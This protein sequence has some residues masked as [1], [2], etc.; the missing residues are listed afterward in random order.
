MDAPRDAV[1]GSSSEAISLLQKV[2]SNVLNDDGF[3]L[4]TDECK[5]CLA[6]ANPLK[7]LFQQPSPSCRSHAKRLADQL[8]KLVDN[9]KK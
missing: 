6:I 4:P 9:A 1:A 2:I 7:E 8:N 5:R 3:S